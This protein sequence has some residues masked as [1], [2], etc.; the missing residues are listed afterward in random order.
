MNGSIILTHSSVPVSENLT[1]Y[2]S[3]LELKSRVTHMESGLSSPMS[4]FPTQSALQTH[5]SVS[6]SEKQTVFS[7]P[8]EAKSRHAPMESGS[9]S[10]VSQFP[11][12]NAFQNFKPHNKEPSYPSMAKDAHIAPNQDTLSVVLEDDL[13][14]V[15]GCPIIKPKNICP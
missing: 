13:V 9:S 14:R 2:F 10:F 6:V 4:P 5:S 7:S 3:P 12:Q 15:H 1:V 8:L 11:V